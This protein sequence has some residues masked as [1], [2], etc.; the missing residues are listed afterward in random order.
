MKT[1]GNQCRSCN[2]IYFNST[3][4]KNKLIELELLR[5][6]GNFDVICISE[7]WC[8]D[9]VSDAMICGQN[10]SCIRKDRK[11]RPGKPGPGKPGPGKTRKNVLL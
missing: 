1:A 7:T 5:N 9:T 4:V 11:N 6:S 10:Y 2:V 8:N 3:S